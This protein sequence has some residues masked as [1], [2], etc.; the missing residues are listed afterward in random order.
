MGWLMG[1]LLVLVSAGAG[2]F[3]GYVSGKAGGGSIIGLLWEFLLLYA[4]L[5]AQLI[6]HEAGHLVCGLMTGYRFL[7]FRIGSVMLVK[8]ADGRKIKRMSLPGTG[9]QCLMIPPECTDYGTFPFRLYNRGGWL[10]NLL[11]AAL[12]AGTYILTKS[13][14][15]LMLAMTGVIIAATNGI[16]IKTNTITN[17]GYNTRNLICSVTARKAFADQLRINAA[18]YEGVRMKNMPPDWFELPDDAEADNQMIVALRV[19]EENRRMD[20]HDFDGAAALAKELL[21]DSAVTA[22]YAVM[23]KLDILYIDILKNGGNADTHVLSDKSVKSMMRAMKGFPNIIRTSY[24]AAFADGDEQGMRD[25]EKRMQACE[26]VYPAPADIASE[27]ELI[28][29]LQRGE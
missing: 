7:S 5:Y 19:F 17:D 4:A 3:I 16:P 6:L 10:M 29:L 26:R 23:L 22:L 12:A 18:S 15:C 20:A 1:G 11:I 24:A 25:A 13:F 14:F 9:G 8:Y 21:R 28:G 27:R 2:F